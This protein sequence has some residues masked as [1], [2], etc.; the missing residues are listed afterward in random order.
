MMTVDP[1]DL[2][3]KLE[4]LIVNNATKTATAPS[5]QQ[6]LSQSNTVK[7]PRKKYRISN[8]TAKN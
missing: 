3:N 4:A 1:I 6:P 2:N 8:N 7:T 5:A